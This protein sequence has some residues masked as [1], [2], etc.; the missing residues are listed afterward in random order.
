MTIIN[1]ATVL[2]GV[3]AVLETMTGVTP[4]PVYIVDGNY[5]AKYSLATGNLIFLDPGNFSLEDFMSGA[6]G[7]GTNP[8]K[9][10]LEVAITL[11][12]M[13]MSIDACATA[14]DLLLGK[15]LEALKTNRSLSGA[16][17][18]LMSIITG[19]SLAPRGLP[20][21]VEG[22]FRAAQINL[23]IHFRS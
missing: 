13:G 3:K 20:G 8:R 9:Y 18:A 4:L 12:S 11:V 10:T 23:E 14:R 1:T 21:S 7:G 15:A 5:Q 19:G 16:G 17:G 22:T 2:A 6:A